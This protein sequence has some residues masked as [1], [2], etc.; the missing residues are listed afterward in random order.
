MRLR[1]VN[2]LV[3]VAPALTDPEE[4]TAAGLILPAHSSVSPEGVVLHESGNPLYANQGEVVAVPDDLNDSED[5][6][7]GDWVVFSPYSGQIV[8]TPECTLIAIPAD[9]ILAVL[10]ADDGPPDSTDSKESAHAR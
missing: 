7:P 6:L 5:I 3:F 2:H 8:Q 4:K 1:P 9:Q 10:D